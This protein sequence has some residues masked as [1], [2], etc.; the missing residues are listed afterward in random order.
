[1]SNVSNGIYVAASNPN[2]V[3]TRNIFSNL[4]TGLNLTGTSGWNAQ[5]NTFQSNG[6]NI[7]NIGTNSVGVAIP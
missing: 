1:M 5:A 2:T 3:L 7:A 4:G 6:T